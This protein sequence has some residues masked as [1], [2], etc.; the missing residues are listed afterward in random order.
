MSGVPGSAPER[1]ALSLRAALAGLRARD[2]R[3]VRE[4]A[5]PVPAEGPAGIFAARCGGVP[6]TSRDRAEDVMV[7]RRVLGHRYPVVFGLY[8]DERRV[9]DWLPGLPERA[10]PAAAAR[11]TAAALPPV[12]VRDPEC[13]RVDIGRE[14][15]GSLPV[16]RITP[17]D[18][19]SFLTTGLVLAEGTAPDGDCALSVHR[20]LILDDRR[21][22]LSMAPG[23]RLGELLSAALAAGRRLPVT[24]GLGVPPS[25]MIASALG[26]RFLPSG[27]DKLAVAGALA[28]A[29]LAV[30]GAVS[31]PVRV[32]ADSEIVVEGYLDGSTADESSAGPPDVSLPEFLGYDGA[33]RAGLPV[34]TVTAI[35]TRP[36]PFLHS[37][38]GPGREQSVILG[39]A[40][41]LSVALGEPGEPLI[42]DLHFS[43]AG[44]G[45][46]L[47]MVSVRKHG[48]ACDGR[49]GPLARRIFAAHPFAKLIVFVDEDV[50]PAVAEDVLWAVTTRANLGTD[51]VTG[52]GSAPLSMDPS[53][54]PEWA[55]ERGPGGIGRTWIDAT[56][57]YRLRGRVR[58]S[59]PTLPGNPAS[60][61]VRSA[62]DP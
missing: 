39:L 53:Q 16:G 15:L 40:G 44:G 25:A 20:M 14:G 6:A 57:P 11:L 29:P 49:L 48:P 5:E 23:R 31:Q 8:G 58:R 2:P 51:A 13:A 60:S 38:I 22:T 24:V 46:L 9:R 36:D 59:F 33:A 41:A 30:A 27:T 17:R 56:V 32:L 26:T 3:R 1:T 35:T 54:G 42:R 10:T 28:G 18:A 43:P 37:V 55:A 4:V 52:T 62:G 19:G 61:E 34:I 21:L 45:M 12:T 7:F 47:L 50:D